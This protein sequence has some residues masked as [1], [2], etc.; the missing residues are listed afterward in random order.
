[1]MVEYF[2]TYYTTIVEKVSKKELPNFTDE[3]IRDNLMDIVKYIRVLFNT[4]GPA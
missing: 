4:S 3:Q 1:M 2:N